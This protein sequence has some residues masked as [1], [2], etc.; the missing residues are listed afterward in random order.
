MTQ[1]QAADGKAGS[2]LIRL[3]S[4]GHSSYGMDHCVVGSC[5]I[6]GWTDHGSLSGPTV[7]LF[8]D[9]PYQI[10]GEIYVGHYPPGSTY[11][12]AGWFQVDQ[13]FNPQSWSVPPGQE[14]TIPYGQYPKVNGYFQIHGPGF[15]ED[16]AGATP[17]NI[18]DYPRR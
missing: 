12:G 10:S 2:D 4:S 15:V 8:N 11:H 3:V 6:G 1:A 7:H 17:R 16:I 9:A 18:G 13:S 14:I 5:P